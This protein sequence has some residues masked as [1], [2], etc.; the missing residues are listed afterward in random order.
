VGIRRF[1]VFN[2]WIDETTGGPLACNIYHSRK[3][4]TLALM[5]RSPINASISAPFYCHSS[6][7]TGITG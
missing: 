5:R 2:F 6:P 4:V 1:T 7:A 3:S